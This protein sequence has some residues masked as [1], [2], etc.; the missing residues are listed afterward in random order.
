MSNEVEGVEQ[1]L[2]GLDPAEWRRRCAMRRIVE[3]DY[4]RS[5][6][7][8]LDQVLSDMHEV[9]FLVRIMSADDGMYRYRF[10]KRG[11]EWGE[12]RA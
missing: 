12:S 6:P 3:D 10:T 11:I 5:D 7:D 1:M 2:D 9:G 8:C 4:D